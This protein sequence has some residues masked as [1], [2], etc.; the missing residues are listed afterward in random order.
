[1]WKYEETRHFGFFP[2][3][4]N[5]VIVFCK[6]VT[7]WPLKEALCLECLSLL[8]LFWSGVDRGGGGQYRYTFFESKYIPDDKL[9]VR[10]YQQP[11]CQQN[12][13]CG[14]QWF[15][16]GRHPKKKFKPIEIKK[17]ERLGILFQEN[18]TRY[19]LVFALLVNIVIILLETLIM[20]NGECKE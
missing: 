15:W 19:Y 7:Y 18:F 10:V 12:D 3:P 9:I 14:S 4:K 20:K 17:V 16:C 6:W 5:Y 13:D 1:M 8:G 2:S 11:S